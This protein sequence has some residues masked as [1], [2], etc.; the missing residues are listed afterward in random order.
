MDDPVNPSHYRMDDDATKAWK[1]R[2]SLRDALWAEIHPDFCSERTA[3][4]IAR[5]NWWRR[6]RGLRLHLDGLPP[7]PMQRFDP[8]PFSDEGGC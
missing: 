5:K 3:D 7:A 1:G 6:A 4:R 8:D 2:A